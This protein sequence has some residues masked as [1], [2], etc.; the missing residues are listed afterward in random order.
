MRL[1][2]TAT[3][4]SFEVLTE[5]SWVS[6]FAC[7]TLALLVSWFMAGCRLG[8]HTQNKTVPTDNVTGYYS[9]AIQKYS[10]H[11]QLKNVSA[12]V[13]SDNVPLNTIP[14]LLQE[15]FSNPIGFMVQDLNTGKS[16]I[17]NPNSTPDANGSIP[18]MGVTTDL[19]S[20]TYSLS[21]VTNSQFNSN[22]AEN[23]KLAVNGSFNASDAGLKLG[24]FQ[25]FGHTVLTLKMDTDF[26]G[27]CDATMTVIMACYNDVTQCQQTTPADNQSLQ[28]YFKS[29]F[30]LYI[31]I[32]LITANQI[33]DV[34]SMGYELNYQ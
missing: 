34:V 32:G 18:S 28:D 33:Q 25:I 26:A 27:N 8:N 19:G 5:G 21:D 29:L 15:I 11:V 31:S 4:R 17:F 9:M 16:A 1:I 22:C 3:R 24:K 10:A 2:S 14:T 13:T 12:P 23:A 6:Y 30:G 7:G 20:R